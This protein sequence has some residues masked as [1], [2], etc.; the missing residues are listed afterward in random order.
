MRKGSKDR[1]N[2]ARDGYKI[3]TFKFVAVFRGSRICTRLV[4]PP[5]IKKKKKY[6]LLLGVRQNFPQLK[7]PLSSEPRSI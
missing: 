4:Y 6:N 5:V 2:H 7:L 1:N 3:I